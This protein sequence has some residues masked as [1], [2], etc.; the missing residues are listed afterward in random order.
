MVLNADGRLQMLES[1]PIVQ[2]HVQK[3][4]D[5]E[6]DKQNKSPREPQCKIDT[7]SGDSERRGVLVGEE[8]LEAYQTYL[9]AEQSTRVV[10]VTKQMYK[11]VSVFYG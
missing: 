10:K 2:Q 7:S 5:E 9:G 6:A 3:K 11:R 8:V 4:H 1:S